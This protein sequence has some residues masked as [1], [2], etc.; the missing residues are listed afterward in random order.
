MKNHYEPLP[1]EWL[2]K[3]YKEIYKNMSL[4]KEYIKKIDSIK[5]YVYHNDI[6]FQCI[7]VITSTNKYFKI[8]PDKLIFRPKYQMYK[9]EKV[10]LTNNLNFIFNNFCH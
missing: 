10:L 3:A 9:K 7:V 5:P 2:I 1:D 4:D 6:V 8:Y